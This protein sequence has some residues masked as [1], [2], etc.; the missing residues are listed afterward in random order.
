M[1]EAYSAVNKTSAAGTA[2]YEEIDDGQTA[3]NGETDMFNVRVNTAYQT[4]TDAAEA[5][6]QAAEFNVKANECYQ[7][8]KMGSLMETRSVTLV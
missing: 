7:A 4:R 6:V 5:I 8:T 1:N 3:I 2:E